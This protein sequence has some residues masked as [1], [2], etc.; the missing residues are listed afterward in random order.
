MNAARPQ[1]L[2][3]PESGGGLLLLRRSTPLAR[4]NTV[5]FCFG[6]YKRTWRS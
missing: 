3:K 5:Y 2:M 4:R 6:A 1:Q